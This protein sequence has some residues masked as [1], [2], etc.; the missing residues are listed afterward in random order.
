[1]SYMLSDESIILKIFVYHFLCMDNA[2]TD[3]S[4]LLHFF[5]SQLSVLDYKGL[6]STDVLIPLT[7]G[8]VPCHALK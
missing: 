3:N 8:L 2:H 1:M 5:K 4:E 7:K 6:G